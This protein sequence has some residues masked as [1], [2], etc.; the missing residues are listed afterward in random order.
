MATAGNIT[1]V[2]T[3]NAT[4]FNQGLESSLGAITKFQESI[5]KFNADSNSMGRAIDTLFEHLNHLNNE[6]KLFNNNITNLNKFSQLSTAINKM[7][8]GLKI[9]SSETVDVE[10]GI[11]TMNNIFKAWGNTL[12][13]T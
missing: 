13:G 10:Q 8:N 3:L 11:N 7:A 6:L 12:N 1:A 4:K 9:L 2:L 5:S